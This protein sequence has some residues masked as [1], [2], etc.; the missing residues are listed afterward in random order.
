MQ[1]SPP[2]AIFYNVYIPT[3]PNGLQNTARIVREQIERVSKSYAAS[4]TH[5][6]QLY[7]NTVSTNSSL[8][9]QVVNLMKQECAIEDSASKR[10]AIDCRHG[11]HFREG[12]E[13]VTLQCLQEYCGQHPSQRVVYLHSKGSHTHDRKN[14]WWRRH[15]TSAVTNEQCL[16]PPS[17]HTDC[18]VCGLVFFAMPGFMFRGN[19]WTAQCQYVNQLIRPGRDWQQKLQEVSDLA[20]AY[21]NEQ[22]RFHFMIQ[23]DTGDN[24]G[25]QR[26]AN[27]HWIGAHPTLRPCELSGGRTKM[28]KTGWFTGH[29]QPQ[30]DFNLTSSPS[31]P[32]NSAHYDWVNLREIRRNILN[33]ET[34]G[35]R[36]FF[37]LPGRV[38]QWKHL[39]HQVPSPDSWT[40]KWFP[41]GEFWIQAL[42]RHG[43]DDVV[44]IVTDEAVKA[45][46]TSLA[47]GKT[48]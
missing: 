42:R 8:G 47:L 5:P 26:Y 43:L 11:N 37:L 34:L 4:Q 16:H 27:E 41:D 1:R 39:Y 12:H 46:N 21:A 48:A 29:P 33:T 14:E 28:H 44:E 20:H 10:R 9:Q 19:M 22:H 45:Y 32:L 36:S 38:F 30:R 31:K 40:W 3:T 2:F 23:A 25:L 7:Y 17:R 15:M 35:R 18:N 6:V 24:F 13:E